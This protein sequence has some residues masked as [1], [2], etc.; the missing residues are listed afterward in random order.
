MHIPITSSLVTVSNV[1]LTCHQ[2]YALTKQTIIGRFLVLAA[3]LRS[4]S[5][6][7]VATS[8]WDGNELSRH[9]VKR[10]RVGAYHIYR[11]C[12]AGLDVLFDSYNNAFQG[13]SNR[14]DRR[15]PV[16]FDCARPS[17]SLSIIWTFI[18]LFRSLFIRHPRAACWWALRLCMVLQ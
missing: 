11:V 13:I 17:S 14:L 3:P 15:S 9:S 10:P 16:S 18:S 1:L 12:A 8:S 4:V 7:F 5:Q 2:G 6:C